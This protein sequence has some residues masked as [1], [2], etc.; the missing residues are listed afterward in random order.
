MT[1]KP[2]FASPMAW[3]PI[4]HETSR[5][6]LDTGSPSL[7]HHAGELLGLCRDTLVPVVEDQV[8]KA[9]HPVVELTH[10]RLPSA[11]APPRPS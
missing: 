6:V 10:P 8:V 7:P 1:A 2:R 4:P 11:K 3:V 5:I 9:R